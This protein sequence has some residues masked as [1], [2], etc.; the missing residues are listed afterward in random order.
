MSQLESVLGTFAETK[1][2]TYHAVLSTLVSLALG[3]LGLG[4]LVKFK[5]S[6][7]DWSGTSVLFWVNL[8]LIIW[9]CDCNSLDWIS[10]Q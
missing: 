8:V 9:L 10:H 1:G 3:K 4:G 2:H 7:V 5:E 6:T